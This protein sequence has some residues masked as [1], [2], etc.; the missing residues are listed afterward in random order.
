MLCYRHNAVRG[1]PSDKISLCPVN[2][3][4]PVTVISA[5]DMVILS[6]ILVCEEIKRNVKMT[7]KN[8]AQSRPPAN[9]QLK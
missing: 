3:Q 6:H 1:R 4:S 7:F 9:S 2:S 8:L 5:E